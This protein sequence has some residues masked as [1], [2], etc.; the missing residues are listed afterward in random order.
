MNK[1]RVTLKDFIAKY[2][3]V[4]VESTVKEEEEDKESSLGSESSSSSSDE[5]SESSTFE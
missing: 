1:D 3:P 4:K 2:G 5:S